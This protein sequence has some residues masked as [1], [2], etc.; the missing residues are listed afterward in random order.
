MLYKT[1][2]ALHMIFH[3]LLLR[4]AGEFGNSMNPDQ[5]LRA[6]KSQLLHPL[7]F[8]DDLCLIQELRLWLLKQ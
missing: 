8:L 4:E 5:T 1:V 6:F 7:E 3:F 2:L